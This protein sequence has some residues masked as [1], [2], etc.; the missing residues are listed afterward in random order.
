MA[1]KGRVWKAVSQSMARSVW[2]GE[3][4]VGLVAGGGIIFAEP[5]AGVGGPIVEILVGAFGECLFAEFLAQAVEGVG[6]AGGEFGL[7]H[8]ADVGLDEGLVEEADDEGG[9][10]GHQQAPGGVGFA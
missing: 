4:V 10:V 7:G 2:G 5:A 1:T 6:E 3:V 8:G 9:V